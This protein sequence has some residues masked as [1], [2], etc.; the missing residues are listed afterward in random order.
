MNLDRQTEDQHRQS[1]WSLCK[2]SATFSWNR[3]L[4][5]S[6]SQIH[7]CSVKKLNAMA[8]VRERTIPTERPP[9]V[10]EVS[11]NFC[12]YRVSRGQRDGFLRPYSRFS[13]PKPLLF[14]S[15]S[16][17]IVLTRLSGPR[18]RPTTQKIWQRRE[19]NPD[20]WICS[21]ELWPLDHWDGSVKKRLMKTYNGKRC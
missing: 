2:R 7:D 13:R 9:L 21:Q 19:S 15:S 8:W 4:A 20:L 14:I 16:S 10:D 6:R 5:Y 11:A 3:L 17:S 18:S 12:W 1:V